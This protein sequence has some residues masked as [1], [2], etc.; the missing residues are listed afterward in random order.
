VIQISDK[1]KALANRNVVL[2]F[3]VSTSVVPTQ[4]EPSE[5]L[6]LPYIAGGAGFRYNQRPPVR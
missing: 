3:F 2:R 5:I 4:F 6:D 1:A